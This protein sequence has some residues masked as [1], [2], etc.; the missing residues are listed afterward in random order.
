[1]QATRSMKADPFWYTPGPSVWVGHSSRVVTL[2]PNLADKSALL[3]SIAEQLEI[4]DAR[5]A[6]EMTWDDLVACLS[7]LDWPAVASV[8]TVVLFH[9]A[10][11]RFRDELLAVY[12]D[13]LRRALD[14][15]GNE[16]PRLVVAFPVA[17]HQK[18]T[19]LSRT[20]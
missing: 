8:G 20:S 4:P 10:L 7:E 3:F 12:L 11:P 9:F 18:V 17:V 14:G 1:M 2:G 13:A 16:Q 15:R 19:T 6:S 5:P